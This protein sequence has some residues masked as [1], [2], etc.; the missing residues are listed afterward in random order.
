MIS[1]NMLG[2]VV[3]DQSKE[4]GLGVGEVERS[5]LAAL[6]A[7]KGNAV[8][9]VKGVRRSGKSTLLKQ[10][11]KKRFAG[12]FHYFN[13]DDER[14]AGFDTPDFQTLHEVLVE[15]HGEQDY[16]FLDEIQN[17]AGW[18]LFV[19]RMLRQGKHVFITG[20]NAN[21]LSAELGT[22]L[23]GRHV[24]V[25]LYPFS[26]A[27]YLKAKNVSV[28]PGAYSTKERADCA[29]HF[30]QYLEK[31]GMPE[32]ATTGNE[33]VLLQLVNDVIQ[34][35]VLPRHQVR[36]PNEVKTVFKFLISNAGNPITF[37]SLK[38]N[39]AIESVATVQKYVELAEET[40]LVFTVKKFETK[41]KQV[42]KNPRKVYCVD[43]GLVTKNALTQS[44]GALLENL[45]AV[46]LKRL[47]KEFY[48]HSNGQLKADFVI[49]KEKTVI[50]SCVELTQE[51]NERELKGLESAFKHTKSKTGLILTLDQRVPDD[52]IAIK[53]AW[54][55]LL[56]TEP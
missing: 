3:K 40:F 42:D 36:K 31:G 39:F 21:P 27:E 17:V 56:E 30:K 55:W 29:K 8:L 7:Y 28:K 14:V 49:P 46:H 11:M 5:A 18:E 12:Q 53:P 25:D 15:Q 32:A 43:N 51:N 2:L 52:R 9:V 22:H 54:E 33:S 23:T 45:I 34:R 41:F 1:K 13:F 48:Y 35:D 26:F 24:D 50:Q 10:L 20:S 6:C 37:N 19:N 44:K 16:L 47:G 38:N 4:L